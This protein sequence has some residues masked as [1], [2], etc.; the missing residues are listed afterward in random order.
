VNRLPQ[1]AAAADLDVATDF[2]QDLL[3]ASFPPIET[4]RAS[5]RVTPCVR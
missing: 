4:R 2:S 3:N 1:P 5:P